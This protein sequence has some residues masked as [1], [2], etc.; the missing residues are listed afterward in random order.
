[1]TLYVHPENQQLLWNVI[2]QT[3]AVQQFFSRYD[4]AYQEKWFKSVIQMF[5]EKNKHLPLDIPALHVLNRETLSYMIS[6][7]QERTR[8][9]SLPNNVL[10]PAQPEVI[11]RENTHQIRQEVLNS[12]FTQRQKE[13]ESMVQRPVKSEIDFRE[14]ELDTAIPNMEE[15]V[16]HHMKQREEE[17]KQYQPPILPRDTENNTPPQNIKLEVEELPTSV[18]RKKNVSWANDAPVIHDSIH[19]IMNVSD[20]IMERMNMQHQEINTLRTV[21]FELT[22]DIQLLKQELTN[23][24]TKMSAS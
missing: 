16:Q 20:D 14:K 18:Q 22:K 13:Y 17:L 12:Q 24:V 2:Q 9:P 8:A 23:V 3:T 19:T 21:V 7:I 11:S 5:Y 6:S 10:L 15:L 1:M 4:A